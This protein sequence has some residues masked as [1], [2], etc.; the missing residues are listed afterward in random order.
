MINRI[1]AV[2]LLVMVYV[3]GLETGRTDAVQAQ[4]NHP[5]CHQNLKP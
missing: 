5:A 1:A 2:V 3:A 4:H